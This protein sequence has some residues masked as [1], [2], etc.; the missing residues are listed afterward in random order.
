[1]GS[2]EASI[3]PLFRGDDSR[4]VA[5]VAQRRLGQRNPRETCRARLPCRA[6]RQESDRQRRARLAQAKD[7]GER[8]CLSSVVRVVEGEGGAELGNAQAHRPA[9]DRRAV[10]VV[11]DAARD[12]GDDEGLALR[13]ELVAALAPVAWPLVNEEGA[14]VE[15]RLVYHLHARR[16]LPVAGRRREDEAR[17]VCKAGR[18]SFAGRRVEPVRPRAR[19][20]RQHALLDRRGAL[21]A[22][23]PAQRRKA[24][25]GEPSAGGR[26]RV[27]ALRLS[28]AR[29]FARAVGT[30]LCARAG[31]RLVLGDALAVCGR[32]PWIAVP[33]ILHVLARDVRHVV[34]QRARLWLGLV[35]H[36]IDAHRCRR[37]DALELLDGKL[38]RRTRVVDLIND[39]DS[40]ATDQRAKR[41]GR[42]VEPLLAN[43]GGVRRLCGVVV[44]LERDGED[45]LLYLGP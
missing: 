40:A 3:D 39:E 6:L 34:G 36:H 31:E 15:E 44:Q 12:D 5:R 43:H 23:K 32:V 2:V 22:A 29:P 18:H 13:R 9:L 33:H 27:R 28:L 21:H 24:G 4:P 25:E 35:V 41:A 1:M 37:V 14:R 8:P 17:R 16:Q 38:E 10:R 26:R 7:P 19:R 30:T 45:R 42:L 20:H 11:G